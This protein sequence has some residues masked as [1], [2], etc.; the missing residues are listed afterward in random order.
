VDLPSETTTHLAKHQGVK[1][2]SLCWS[3]GKDSDQRP[4][5]AR[6]DKRPYWL[7][8]CFGES[9]GTLRIDVKEVDTMKKLSLQKLEKRIAPRYMPF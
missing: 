2:T 8:R 7:L 4:L 9:S 5:R 1:T 3:G 6:Q